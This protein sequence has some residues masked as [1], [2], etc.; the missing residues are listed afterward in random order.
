MPGIAML[1]VLLFGGMQT[2]FAEPIS[3]CTRPL[4]IRASETYS[5]FSIKD[6]NGMAAGIDNQFIARVMRATGCEFQFVFMP[7]KR[8]LYAIEHGD[9]DILPSASFT[10]ERARYGLF[11]VPYRNDIFGFVV[12]KGDARRIKLSSLE[13]VVRQQLVIGY[14]R[15][16]YRGEAFK[17]FSENPENAPYIADVSM[18]PHGT[19]LLMAKRI[20][21]L[22][23]LPA[24]YLAQAEALGF[25]GGVEEHPFILAKEPVRLMF[26]SKTISPQ[27][28]RRLSN[29]ITRETFTD[30]YHSLFGNQSVS[31]N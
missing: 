29:A 30:S 20:D 14:V 31:T 13:D 2:S 4:V 17:T 21:L 28:A 10:E 16:A 18:A 23:G 3:D 12:R 7:W 5:P 8:A 26:S 22:L 19:Q 1:F 25:S 9:I 24:A 6:A 27:L 11:S 15:G